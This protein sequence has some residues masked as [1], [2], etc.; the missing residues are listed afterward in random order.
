MRR[1]L[2]AR[3]TARKCLDAISAIVYLFTFRLSYFK[4]VIK[5]YSEYK[6]YSRSYPGETV[7]TEYLKEYGERASVKGIYRKWIILESALRGKNIFR[8]IREKNFY[9]I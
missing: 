9:K 3:I 1:R 7:L 5:A 4:A 8:S 2:T 6:D